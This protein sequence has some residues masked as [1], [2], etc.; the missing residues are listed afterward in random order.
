MATTFTTPIL[1]HMGLALSA[2]ALGPL[3]LRARKGSPLHRQAG[4]T[5]VVLMLGAAFSS[6]FIRNTQGLNLGGYTP[7]HLLTLLTFAGI[8]SA[9]VAVVR[10]RIA[11]HRKAM[12]ST[13]LGGCL[14]AGLFT[15]LPS[16][17]L[18]QCLW[19]SALGWV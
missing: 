17:L 19:H 8:T 12:W 16:R 7:I 4:Y 15:L 11:E 5:W 13:Y 6:L 3:A 14:V 9:I 10:G 18:G 2:L 1:I